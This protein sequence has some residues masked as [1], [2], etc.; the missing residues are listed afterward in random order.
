MLTAAGE[1]FE[2]GDRGKCPGEAKC[3]DWNQPFEGSYEEKEFAICYGCPMF[4]SKP[5]SHSSPDMDVDEVESIVDDIRDMVFLAD[6][7]HE[8][9]WR[10][11]DID[12]Y[13][14]FCEWRA[15]EK[16]VANQRSIRIDQV[17]KANYFK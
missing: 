5:A 8:T 1:T 16:H 2:G 17:L 10:E 14:L 11:Y 13:R 7:G 4:T 12:I 15:A 3:G 9:D 6:G